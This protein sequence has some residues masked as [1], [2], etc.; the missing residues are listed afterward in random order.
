MI[1]NIALSYTFFRHNTISY[2]RSPSTR[3][4]NIFSSFS[5]P[6][7]SEDSTSSV[8]FTSASSSPSSSSAGSSSTGSFV[9]GLRS[10][11]QRMPPATLTFRDSTVSLDA[12]GIVTS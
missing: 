12:L 11:L 10:A 2:I 5:S 8:S 1:Y 6:P 7:S 9:Y 4:Q 3:N